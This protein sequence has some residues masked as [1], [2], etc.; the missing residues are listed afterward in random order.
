MKEKIVATHSC[1]ARSHASAGAWREARRAAYAAKARSNPGS[2]STAQPTGRNAASLSGKE[3]APLV[4]VI[5]LARRPDR[6][7]ALSGR[8]LPFEWERLEAV[9][10]RQLSWSA[11]SSHGTEYSGLV[12]PEAVAQAMWAEEQRM[13]TICRRTG[14]FSPHLTLGAVGIALSQRSAWQRLLASS[15]VTDVALVVED[16]IA[17]VP[18]DFNDK[19]AALLHTLPP[20]WH[21]CFLGYHESTGVLLPAAEPPKL[22]ELPNGVTLTGLYAYLIH[23]RGAKALLSNKELF[24]L[25]MQVDVALSRLAWPP[26]TRFAL[27]PSGVLVTSPKSEEGACDTDIQTLGARDEAAHAK[28]PSTMLR[29]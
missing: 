18:P 1:V 9:D 6:L 10:G 19:V 2:T 21:V 7:S 22:L 8:G 29:L 11:L 20:T 16:D 5:N 4:I 13:P 12:H 3:G 28:L 26:G 24:P 27:D 14:S 15:F 17:A 25:R 23:R